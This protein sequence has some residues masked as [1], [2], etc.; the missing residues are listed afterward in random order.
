MNIRNS[1]STEIPVDR[2]VGFWLLGCGGLVAGMVSIGGLTRLTKSGL[3]ITEWKPQGQLPPMNQEEWQIQFD[4]YKT[5]PEWQQRKSM[6]LDEFKYI[7]WWEYGHR[8]LGRFVGVA[9]GVPMMYF[10]AR[11]RIPPHLKTR[12]AALLGLGGAQGLVGAWMV[13]SGLEMDPK[14]RKEIRVSPY[15][16]AAHLG[17]AFTTYSLLI[18]TALD[19]F[20]PNIAAVNQARKLTPEMISKIGRLRGGAVLTAGLVFT[21]AMSGAFVAGNDAGRAYNTFPTMDGEWVP[22][23]ALELMPKWRNIFESTPMVQFD[24]RCFALA[25]TTAVVGTFAAARGN[26]A[27]WTALPPKARA[28]LMGMLGMVSVQVSLGIG[29]LLMYV[30]TN[31][32]ASHQFGSLL[33][34]TV[35]SLA[36]HSL[37]GFPVSPLPFA[38]AG[39]SSVAAPIL[40]VLASE[41]EKETSNQSKK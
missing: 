6:T 27:L 34:L 30:P 2:S 18:W 25:S 23:N 7:F 15:R 41:E 12:V 37:K 20:Y 28:H 9:F 22:S 4:K 31:M 3:S 16:L 26:G 10:F 38:I 5:F 14:Q 17:M 11:G 1:F 8:M 33:L 13:Q 39:V 24:H 40:L 21:T 36:A 32:A 19:V 29:T 35:S